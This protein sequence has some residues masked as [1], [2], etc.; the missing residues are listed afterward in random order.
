MQERCPFLSGSP[1][2]VLADPQMLTSI[3]GESASPT[4]AFE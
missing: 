4:D 2:T 3:Q 1:F